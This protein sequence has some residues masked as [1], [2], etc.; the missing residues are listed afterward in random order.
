MMM[1][2]L[3]IGGAPNKAVVI[4][5]GSIRMGTAR[6]L[7]GTFG[8][9]RVVAD[10]SCPRCKR[11]RTLT[12]LPPN[13]KCADVICDFCG[14]LAQ[15]KAAR[16]RDVTVVP[17][18]VLGA[19]WGPQKERMD[20]AIYFPLFLVLV[21]PSRLYSIFYLSADLQSREMFR[22]RTP[23]S[24]TARRAGWQGFIYEFGLAH[25]SFVRLR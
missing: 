12:R 13:F 17:K 22:A 21:G 4:A 7:L 8:E 6:Q 1:S 5:W 23:L 9:Q 15:V 19:A 16:V 2:A 20:A 18:T 24:K 25:S 10:C 3:A 11:V 14:Y